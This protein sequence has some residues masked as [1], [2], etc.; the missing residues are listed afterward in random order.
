MVTAQ[1]LNQVEGVG[2]SPT[3]RS[4][5]NQEIDFWTKEVHYA[6]KKPMIIHGYAIDIDGVNVGL[7]AYGSPP[8]RSFNNG[9]SFFDNEKFAALGAIVLELNRL[10][11]ADDFPENE[12]GRVVAMSLK[13][14][15]QSVCAA[16]VSYADPNQGHVGYIY[17]ATN[18]TYDGVAAARMKFFVNG[19]SVPERSIYDRYGTSAL[20]KLPDE[21]VARRQLGKHR[22]WKFVGN[23]YQRR[24]LKQMYQGQDL[25]YPKQDNR[26]YD[27]HATN[28]QLAAGEFDATT[29]L[30][31]VISQKAPTRG[32]TGTVGFDQFMSYC[33]TLYSIGDKV[34]VV[35][36]KDGDARRRTVTL[37]A[38]VK[39]LYTDTLLAFE[40]KGYDLY[41][42]GMPMQ[43]QAQDMA[44]RIW[45]D[46]DN[47]KSRLPRGMP[48]PNT[49]VRTS[50]VEGGGFRWQAIW[51]LD[52][53]IPR[54][55]AKQVMKQLAEMMGAD[56]SVHDARRILRI[57]GLINAKRG[58]KAVLLDSHTKRVSL[59]DFELP[60][61]DTPLASILSTPVN[62]PA[63][64]LGE[65][66]TGI[67]EG[68][69]NRVSY[70]CAR[71]LKS[72]GVS[73]ADALSIVALGASRCEPPLADEEVRNSVRSAY[74]G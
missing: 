35:A 47:P 24:R 21:V 25:A 55:R 7:I 28:E 73:A 66:L 60:K 69:R 59:D 52:K 3:I 42:S 67:S 64:V 30:D 6:R 53:P 70:V 43:M 54:D 68:E 50:T 11:V 63:A 31:D 26:R 71:F 33:D 10:V 22:Y 8:N 40:A 17:Q 49:L 4:A 74:N 18:W 2:S 12:L 58:M 39:P 37:D 1:L 57:P 5:S 9:A 14:L 56:G 19:V 72:C 23:K 65:W 48:K 61:V 32:S 36:I 13:E 15:G 27:I 16:V 20:S 51:L 41:M 45:V 44:D 38:N 62:N 29:A 34:E 46:Q